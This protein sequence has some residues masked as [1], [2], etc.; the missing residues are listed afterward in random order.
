MAMATETKT[1]TEQVI[2]REDSIRDAGEVDDLEIFGNES[3]GVKFRTLSWP[4]ATVIFLKLIFATGV[5]SIPTSMYQ[6][7]AVGGC[8]SVIGWTGWNQYTAVILYNFRQRH[9]PCHSIADMAGVLAGR[10][11]KEL[12]GIFFVVGNIIC[13]GS[14]V[15][16]VSTGLN[17][18]S[19]HA[20]CTV[21]W[22]L[23]GFVVI[24]GFASIRKLEQLSWLTWAGFFSVFIAV[25]IIVVGVTQIDRPAAAPP[26]GPFELGFYAFPP[27]NPTFEIG[28]LASCNIYVSSANTGA[29]VPVIAEMKNPRDFKKAV[30]VCMSMIMA[31]YVTFSLAVYAYCGK[32]VA[33][34]SLGSAGPTIKMVAY[35]VGLWGLIMSGAVYTHVAAK[36]TFVRLLRNTSHLQRNTVIH[37]STWLG[38]T[39]GI[40]ALG[41]VIAEA[42]PIFNYLLALL[43]SFVYG[44][45]NIC[46]PAMLWL[47]DHRD[48]WRSSSANLKAKFRFKFMNQAAY[49]FHAFFLV[50]GFFVTV[51]GTYAVCMEIKNA[52]DDGTIGS[53]FSCADNSN[54]S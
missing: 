54:S 3:N 17:A 50:L 38:C 19:H 9:G 36:Y 31:F 39:I 35:G 25:F 41:F 1:K 6:L 8:L 51:G 4:N 52:Y 15:I 12:T 13:T 43:G 49:V 53:A 30:H 27:T 33:S 29:F 26:T 44:P 28:M 24:A 11:G 45:L 32:W 7:G 40:S 18:L 48:W 37:W 47:F 10:A 2:D 22:A 16:A 34:P 21:W 14:A 23:I 42:V 46:L 5:L 20:A